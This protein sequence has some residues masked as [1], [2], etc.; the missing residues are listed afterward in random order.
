[1]GEL[2]ARLTRTYPIPEDVKP[3]RTWGKFFD[4]SSGFS[5]RLPKTY[6]LSVFVDRRFMVGTYK[7]RTAFLSRDRVVAH[8]V[9]CVGEVWELRTERTGPHRIGAVMYTDRGKAIAAG[10]G[11]VLRD[12]TV[13]GKISTLYPGMTNR[14]KVKY[15]CSVEIDSGGNSKVV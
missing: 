12:G 10:T 7:R 9:S 3:K 6:W 13:R 8:C 2:S 1:M 15:E 11:E 14:A 5:L 4:R